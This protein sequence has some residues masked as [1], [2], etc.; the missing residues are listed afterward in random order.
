MECFSVWQLSSRKAYC[1]VGSKPS[2]DL[3]F[4]N[5]L[6]IKR[7]SKC[8]LE[9]QLGD[10]TVLQGDFFLQVLRIGTARAGQRHLDC[11]YMKP[12]Q[13]FEKWKMQSS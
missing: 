6:E 7:A 3:F 4:F 2:K 10:W 9:T 13:V 5:G 11:V 1:Y 12:K 8:P